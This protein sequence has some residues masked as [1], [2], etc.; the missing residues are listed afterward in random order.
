MYCDECGTRLPKD[1]AFC[2]NC[3]HSLAPKQNQETTIQ[4]ESSA[5]S[6]V[7]KIIS[8]FRYDK[9]RLG[10]VGVIVVLLV[11]VAIYAIV[12]PGIPEA[13]RIDVNRHR[14]ASFGFVLRMLHQVP[15]QTDDGVARVDAES[16][17]RLSHDN[18]V[19]VDVFW[20][21]NPQEW[22]IILGEE[23]ESRTWT[24]REIEEWLSVIGI[25]NPTFDSGGR[26]FTLTYD[27]DSVSG[28][29][30]FIHENQSTGAQQRFEN[31][32]TFSQ[33]GDGRVRIQIPDRNDRSSLWFIVQSHLDGIS[34][35]PGTSR[36]FRYYWNGSGR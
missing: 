6:I 20:R 10:I 31:Q 28:G 7:Q 35:S 8:W 27:S 36:D 22:L 1:S 33:R 4:E 21:E 11:S 2:E 34:F 14:N 24:K 13:T 5:T 26:Q 30:V 18:D 15:F 25:E 29:Y 12:P 32:W 9:K 23:R 16:A 17:T 19:P 3:G